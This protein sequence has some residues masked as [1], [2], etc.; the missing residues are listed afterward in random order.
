M[1]TR[2]KEWLVLLSTNVYEIQLIMCVSL[3]GAKGER[4]T[5]CQN[6][7]PNG[8]PHAGRRGPCHGPRT[9]AFVISSVP[10]NR[11]HLYRAL[12]KVMIF[13]I[14]S[15]LSLGVSTMLGGV[16]CG[17]LP[18]QMLLCPQN[19]L[20]GEFQ[21]EFRI[22]S[23]IPANGYAPKI[24]HSQVILPSLLPSDLTNLDS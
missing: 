1:E 6:A 17:L 12:N 23:V 22:K 10:P 2:N 20:L 14:G 13:Q 8:F 3:F 7:T 4:I 16:S 9:R 18:L 15:M 19:F 11:L 5:R 24:Q 21:L